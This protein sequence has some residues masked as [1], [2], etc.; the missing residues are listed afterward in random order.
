M[1]ITRNYAIEMFAQLGHMALGH[2]DEVTLTA[3]LDNF[4]ALR[5]ASE[6]FDKLR[7]ELNKRLYEG[8][9]EKRKEEFFKLVGKLERTKEAEK[10]EELARLMKDTYSDFYPLYEKHLACIVKLM[11]KEIEVE[12]T[13]VDADAFVKGI[14]KGKQDAPVME[15][16]AYF[17]PMFKAEEKK[18]TDFAELD[19]LL[20]D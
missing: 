11:N 18:D 12:I 17:A 8:M 7:E 4:N 14:V 16:R 5:K 6:D 19:E 2:L 1:K 3:T 15:I 13:E 9:D 20:K 10:R